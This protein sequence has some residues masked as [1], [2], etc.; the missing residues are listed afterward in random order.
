MDMKQ[1]L[2]VY[3]NEQE[4]DIQAFCSGGCR[5]NNMRTYSGADW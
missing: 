5:Y 1:Y 3:T 4:V 2:V